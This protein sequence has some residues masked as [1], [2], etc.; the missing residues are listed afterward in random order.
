MLIAADFATS[1]RDS[2]VVYMT[3]KN[4]CSCPTYRHVRQPDFDLGGRRGGCEPGEEY[5]PTD[6]FILLLGQIAKV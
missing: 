6:P 2:A 5:E 1:G 4:S 3:V